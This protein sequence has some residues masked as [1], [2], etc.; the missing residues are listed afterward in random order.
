[1]KG[2]HEELQDVT[3]GKWFQDWVLAK[4]MAWKVHIETL[5]TG[6]QGENG[7]GGIK[8]NRSM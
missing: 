2:P 7:H 5:D 8:P 4:E 6:A 1:M 3:H